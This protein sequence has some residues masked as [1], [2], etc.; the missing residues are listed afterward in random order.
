MP[1][2][3]EAKNSRRISFVRLK[4]E[5]AAVTLDIKLPADVEAKYAAE[6]R[7]RGV[8]LERHLQDCLIENAPPQTP[9]HSIETKPGRV[10]DLPAM[11]GTVIGSLHRRD[12]YQ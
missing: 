5:S 3:P 4:K 12:I 7:A 9:Q 2:V 10:R 6:A 11:R 8:P 1:Y